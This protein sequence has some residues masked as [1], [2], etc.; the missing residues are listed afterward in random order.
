MK[1]MLSTRDLIIHM[2]EKGIT[3]DLMSEQEASIMLTKVNYYFKVTSYRNNFSKS[4]DGKYQNLDF[5]YLTDLASIDMQLR[6]Y[7]FDLSID[8]E[9]SIK[10]LILN[11]ISNDNEEDG[12]S[13]VDDFRDMYPSHYNKTMEYLSHNKYLYDMYLKHHDHVAIWV[14]LEVMTFGTL[15]LFVDFY[16]ARK[17]TKSVK[18]IHNYLKFSKNIRNAC[19]HSNPL[20]VNIFSDKEFLR[21][22]SA[23]IKS[24]AQQMK[25]PMNYLQDLKINDLVSLFY[26]HQ[27]LQSKKMSEHRCRQGRRL[28]KRFHRHEDWYADNTKLNTFFKVLSNLIDYLE[29]K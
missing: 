10:V 25:I 13:I 12:Y 7:L 21:K 4:A 5:A 1:K 14:F 17:P 26:L 22:P 15:S 19:A 16:L 11:L 2:K 9:H 3:F 27:S 28:I 8:I 18:K 24:A 6:D 23:P 20:L 29:V